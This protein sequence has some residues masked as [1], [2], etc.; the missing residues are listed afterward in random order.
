MRLTKNG[1]TRTRSDEKIYKHLANKWCVYKTT[2][3]CWNRNSSIPHIHTPYLLPV[4]ICHSDSNCVC[5]VVSILNRWKANVLRLIIRFFCSSSSRISLFAPNVARLGGFRL[6]LL[7]IL[8]PYLCS[9]HKLNH[10]GKINNLICI[11]SSISFFFHCISIPWKSHGI[12][13]QNC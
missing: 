9:L 11:S 7:R 6:E 5:R 1:V 12:S 2:Y 3:K 8:L 10:K 13:L 4:L